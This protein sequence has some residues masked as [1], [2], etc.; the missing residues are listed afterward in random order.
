MRTTCRNLIVLVLIPLL[1]AALGGC[2]LVA[3]IVAQFAPPQDVE[4]VYEPPE[5]KTVLVFVDDFRR[6]VSYEPIKEALAEGVAAELVEHEVAARTI[7][8]GKFEDLVHS[9]RDFNRMPIPNVGR[10]LG[11]DLVV[12]VEIRRFS[13]KEDDQS[14]LWQGQMDVNVKVVNSQTGILW[15]KGRPDGYPVSYAEREPSQDLSETYGTVVAKK[16]AAKMSRKVARL[17]Y[18]HKVPAK[19]FGDEE[20]E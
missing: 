3:F 6:P 20:E 13:L 12:Y 5:G 9:T 17:F 1:T 18:D 15:P 14:P 7:P 11:A 10:E 4:A 2:Q 8:Y 19:V 16:V